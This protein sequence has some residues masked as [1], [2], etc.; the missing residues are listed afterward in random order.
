MYFLCWGF[1]LWHKMQCSYFHLWCC[2]GTQE[3]SDFECF[4]ISWMIKLSNLGTFYLYIITCSIFP[5]YLQV[6]EFGIFF[7]I[8]DNKIWACRLSKEQDLMMTWLLISSLGRICWRWLVG[9]ARLF[10]F[11]TSAIHHPEAPRSGSGGPNSVTW[12][13]CVKWRRS[14]VTLPCPLM[15]RVSVFGYFWESRVLE[16]VVAMYFP[17]KEPSWVVLFGGWR[18]GLTSSWWL[19]C[20]DVVFKSDYM[21]SLLLC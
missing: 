1:S 16:P 15:K 14:V 19:S 9:V 18:V 10:P 20:W 2:I 21:P 3:I 17:I 11:A 8:K 6:W 13:S 4:F 12:R 7:N 5:R